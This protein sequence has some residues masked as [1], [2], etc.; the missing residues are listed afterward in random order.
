MFLA[1]ETDITAPGTHLV[2]DFGMILGDTLR[3]VDVDLEADPIR[4]STIERMLPDGLPVQGLVL[5]GVTIK[6]EP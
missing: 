2:G 3:F 1:R 4:V 6:G 5:G